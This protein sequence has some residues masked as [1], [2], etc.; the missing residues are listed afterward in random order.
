MVDNYIKP[1]FLQTPGNDLRLHLL[2]TFLSCNFISHFEYMNA[3]CV[4]DFQQNKLFMHI[5]RS[6]DSIARFKDRIETQFLNF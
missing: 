6:G 3:I 2:M 5:A 4:L 1:V